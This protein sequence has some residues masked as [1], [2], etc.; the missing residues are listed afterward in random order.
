MYTSAP[1]DSAQ[2]QRRND[3]IATLAERRL[4]PGVHIVATSNLRTASPSTARLL[5]PPRS[6]ASGNPQDYDPPRADPA[7]APAGTRQEGQEPQ[8]GH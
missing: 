3:I 4:P 8:H 2:Q 6:R 7:P 1:D 5:A